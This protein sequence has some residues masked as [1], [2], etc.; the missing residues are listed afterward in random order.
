MKR[1][2]IN[3]SI[4]FILLCS[5]NT[6]YPLFATVQ[7]WNANI[8]ETQGST[9]ILYNLVP[10]M[11]VNVEKPEGLFCRVSYKKFSGWIPLKY[12]L[13]YNNQFSNIKNKAILSKRIFKENGKDYLI[14]YKN[15]KLN[16]F[17]ITDRTLEFSQKIKEPENIFPSTK[18]E[19]FLLEG[20][21]TNGIEIHHY[22]LYNFYTGKTVYIGSYLQH[23]ISVESVQ[24]SDNSEFVALILKMNDSYITCI[25]KTDNGDLI[26]YSKN[27]QWINWLDKTIIMNSRNY[28]WYYDLSNPPADMDIGYQQARSIAAIRPD[29]ILS[30]EIESKIIGGL[31]CINT[32]K[33]VIAID[34]KTKQVKETPLKSLIIN[35]TGNLNFYIKKDKSYLKNLTQNISYAD[36][37]GHDPKIEFMGFSK[38]NI[39]GRTKYDKIEALFLYNEEGREIYRYKA[40]DEPMSQSEDGIMAEVNIDKDLIVIAIENP[41]KDEFYFLFDKEQQ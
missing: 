40:I 28:F 21:T 2:I 38:T 15:S 16:K 6:F 34:Y 23:Q 31:L 39:I 1:L 27:S 10:G 29:W 17:N 13:I 37:Q 33:G 20:I 8:E 9:N 36:F 12:I 41:Q 32:K 5:E 18:N 24:F 26:A 30:G 7:N 35:N 14:F 3:L 25:Y 19:L 4:F 22:Q 11:V